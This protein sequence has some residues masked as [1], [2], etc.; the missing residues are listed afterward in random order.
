MPVLDRWTSEPGDYPIG[1]WSSFQAGDCPRYSARLP[2]GDVYVESHGPRCMAG[3]RQGVW[4]L[5][6]TGSLGLGRQLKAR[7][8]PEACKEASVLLADKLETWVEA[9]R[10]V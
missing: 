7:T 5:T 10:G 9:L 2:S 6:G 3:H 8:G 1:V 4:T